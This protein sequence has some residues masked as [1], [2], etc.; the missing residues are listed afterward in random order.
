MA[1]DTNTPS[2]SLD[3][4]SSAHSDDIFA[5]N[6]QDSVFDAVQVAQAEGAAPPAPAAAATPGAPRPVEIPAGADVVRIQV[7][8]GDVLI[9]GAPFTGEAELIGR[10]GDGNLAIRVGDVTVILQGYVDANQ[11]A[12]ITVETAD[13]Q[14]ID[15]A[16]MLA[17]TDPTID[18]QTAAG[19][20]DAAAGAQGADNN[21]ALFSQFGPGGGL[22]GFRGVG[23]QDAT[24]L[25]YG[26]IDNS[27]RND[28]ADPLVTP[29]GTFGFA[30][31]PLSG[32]HSERFFRDPAQTDYLGTFAKFMEE[33]QD[34][35]ENPENPMFPGWADFQG[36]GATNGDFAEYLQQTRQTIDIDVTFTNGAGDISLDG[37]AAG[38]TSNGSP[39]HVEHADQG[40]TMF[41]RR[42]SDG[43]LV[44]VVHVETTST[45]FTIE[46]ILINRMDHPGHGTGD[47]GRDVMDIGVDFTVYDGPSPYT[48]EG[49]GNDVGSPSPSLSETATFTFEDDVPLFDNVTYDNLDGAGGDDSIT[50]SKSTGL[51]DEDWLQAGAHDTGVDGK[52]NAGDNGD[53]KGGASVHGQINITFG[54]DGPSQSDNGR[55]ETLGKHAFALDTSAYAQGQPFPYGEDGL[56]SGGQTLYVL[57]VSPN[58]LIVGIPAPEIDEIEESVAVSAVAGTP[59]FM[60]TLNQ[61]TGAFTFTLIGPLDHFSDLIFD[62]AAPAV[63]AGAENTIPL[64][65]GVTALDDDG[66]YVP[67]TIH[68]EVNDDMPVARD[69]ENTVDPGTFGPVNGNAMDNDSQG[70]DTA[71]VTGVAFEGKSGDLGTALQGEYGKLTLNADGTY[72][73]TRDPGTKGGVDD[74]FHYTLT[75]KDGD[76]SEAK[77]TIHIGDAGVTVETP[78]GRDGT[79][80]YEAGLPERNGGEPAG[81]GEI[82]DGDGTDNDDTSEATSGVVTITAKDG[83]ASLQIGSNAALTLAELNDLGSNPVSY[84]DSTGELTLTGFD[85]GTGKLSYTY[86]LLDN[87]LVDPDSRSFAIKVTDQDGSE[88]SGTLKITI[89]DDE[90]TARSDSDSVD[91]VAN[92]ATGNVITGDNTTSG[93]AG[94]DT[95]GA[96]GAEAVFLTS[97]DKAGIPDGD[98][99]NGLKVEGLYGTLEMAADGSYTYTRNSDTPLTATETF[100]YALED[101]DGDISPATLTINIDDRGVRIGDL[102]PD[103]AGGDVSVDEDDLSD[104]SDPAPKDSLTATGT[105]TISAPDGVQT[106]TIGGQPVITGGVFAATSFTTPFGNTLAVTGYNSGTGEI[107]Y[108]YKLNDNTSHASAGEDS[109]FEDFA[110]VLTD[111]DGDTAN[112]TLSAKIV[113]DVPTAKNDT[114]SLDN[115]TLTATGN[116][117]TGADTT[118]S[119]AD[120]QGADTAKVIGVS[121]TTGGNPLPDINGDTTVFGKY[122][123]LTVA[124]DGTYTYTRSDG[125]PLNDTDTF[126]YTLRDGDGDESTA[127]LT[128][129]IQD[130]DVEITNLTP[131][132]AG[133][134]VVVDEDDLPGGSDTTPESTAAAGSFNISAPDG[135]QTLTIGGEP[136]IT[137]G[138][139]TPT[140]ITTPLGNTLTVTSFVAGVISYT[141]TLNDNETHNTGGG[142]NN[143]FENLAVEL[144]DVDGD[145]KTSTLSA[146]I[147]DDIAT[148]SADT[149]AVNSGASTGDNVETNDVFGADGKSGQGVIGVATGS[150][151]TKD[152]SGNLNTDIVTSLGTLK[153]QADGTY[154]Y[155]AKPNVSGVDHFVY[156]IKDGDG[157]TSTTTL[158]ITVNQVAPKA[159]TQSVTV[160]EAALDKNL[161]SGDLAIATVTG[162]NPGLTTE[163]ATG[164]LVLGSGV[165][166]VGGNDQS[167]GTGTLHVDADGKFTYTLTSPINSGA[168]AGAN[169]VADSQVFNVTIKDADGNTSIDT[170]KISIKDDIAT[171]NAD[172]KALNSGA[173]TGDNVETN[174]VFGADGKSGQGVIGVAT[175][176]DTTKDASGNLNTDIVTSLGTLKLQADGSYT[177]TAKPNV[178][179]VDHFVYTIKDGDGDTSTTTLDITVNQVVLKTDTQS[180]T[181]DEAALDLTQDPGDLA[182]GTVTG[183]NAGSANETKTGQLVLGSGVTVVGGNDQSNATGT[184]H[185]D[186]DGKFTYTLTSPINSGA[187][188]GANTVADSQVFTVTI[189]DADGN[190]ATD[191]IKISIKDDIATANAD[192]NALNSGAT[193]TGN[194]ETNDVFGA[195]G[196]SGNG[197]VG[198][199]AGT[200]TSSPVSGGTGAVITTSLGKLTLNDNGSYTY[201]ANPNVSGVDHF[202]YTIKDG[203]G[204]LSTT[205]LDITVNQVTPKADT[206][207]VTVDEAALDLTQDP[208]D[209]AAGTVTGSNPG[210]SNETKTGQLVLGSGVTVVGGNDQSNATGTLHVDADGKFTYTLTSPINSGAAA[211]ANTVA[212]SQVF[213]VTIK[214]ADGNTATDTIKISIKD[215]IPTAD[216]DSNSVNSGATATG[217]VESDDTFGADGKSGNGVVGVAAGTDTSSPVLTGTGAM[218][219]TSLGK[220]TLNDDGSYTYVANP[221]KGGVDHF[222]YTIKDGDG[223]LST[224]TLDITVNQV[225]LKTDT[226]SATVD[227]AALDLTQDPGDLA[228]GTVTGSN[229]GSSNETKTGQLVLGSGV[230]VVGGNDQSNATG[231]LHVDADGKFTYTLTSPINSGA[232]AGANTVADAQTFNVTIQDAFGNTA[233]DTIKISIKDDIPTADPD[234]N[235]VNSGATAT[236]NVES[237]D[238]FGA[239]GKSGNGVVGVAAGN[240][241]SSPVLTGTGAVITTSLGKLTLNDDGSYTYVANPNTGGVDHFVYTI[242]DGDGDLSTTTLDI[243][244]NQVAPKADTQS[245]TVDEAA[246]DLTQ[247]P[248]DLAAGTVTGSNPGSSNETKTGQLVLGSGVTVV[249]GN[250]QSNG[251]GTLHVDADGKFTYTLTSPINSGAVAGA[252]TVADAQVFNVTIQD[253]FGNTATDTIKISITDDIPTAN[254]D[255]K[256]LNSGGSTSD[257]VEGNDGFGADGKSGGTGVVG[258]AT[259]SNTAVPVSGN[260]NTNI[261]TSLGTLKLQAD[262]SYTY[263]ANANVSG[264]DHFVYTIKDGDGDQ[265]TTTLDITVNNVTPKADTQIVTVNEAALDTILDPGDLAVSTKTGSNPSSPDETKTGQLVLGAGITATAGDYTGSFGK[266]HVNSDGSFTY[267]LTTNMNSGAVAG[268]NTVNDAEIFNIQIQDAFGN[269][270]TD[271]IKVNIVDDVPQVYDPADQSLL[272]S[273][274]GGIYTGALNTA[275]KGGADGI[276][277]VLFS[278]GTDGS[279]AMLSD[280]STPMLYQTHNILLSGFGT[281][282]LTGT[283]DINNSG[284]I[285]A[286][287]VQVFTVKLDVPNDRYEF[288]LLK[289]I[290]NGA[291]IDFTDLSN[292]KAGNGSWLGVGADA[293]DATTRDLLY[294]SK[295]GTSVNSSS[296]DVA[297]GNQWIEFGEGLRM[298]FVNGLTTGGGGADPYNFTAHY[299]VQDFQFT[300]AQIKGGASSTS[301]KVSIF[302]ATTQA[303]VAGTTATDFGLETAVALS[304]GE[305]SVLRGGV[306]ASG[307]TITFSSGVATIAGIQ[308]GDVIQI[309]EATGFDR[310]LVESGDNK[311]ADFAISSSKVLNTST[312]VDLDTRFETTL[313]DG[314]GDTSKGQYIGINLQTDDGQAHTFTGGS[315]NDTMHGGI[316]NDTLTGGSGNDL[317]FG[318]AGNDTMLYDSADKYDGGAGFDRVKVDGAGGTNLS[319]TSANFISIEMID[320]GDSSDRNGAGQNTLSLNATDLIAAN[321]GASTAIPGHNIN[322]FVIG[323]T[324]GA[325]TTEHDNVVLTGFGGKLATGVAFVDPNTGIS[326]NYDVYATTANP[327]VK[328]A[329]ETNLDVT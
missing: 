245:V 243:T 124:A 220:L 226:Q 309:D 123:V 274:L 158:D 255:T 113:D 185:V 189:Q 178:Q 143:L 3:R 203:D 300:L 73:Y 103:T 112:S 266:L 45:G 228:A 275:G 34:A 28:F 238:T 38:L 60:L 22:G 295:T 261:V 322:L 77:L 82:A 142:E 54:A 294:T 164:Q 311:S 88:G 107:T 170:I 69:D 254:A 105:F 171:A 43:A 315:G 237:D 23:A 167:N 155:T 52:S 159:D 104:G 208:G 76:T 329:I 132:T 283:A 232:V 97:I 41:V 20:G 304:A 102:N 181:V 129:N 257:N 219:T 328:V 81:S 325:G 299:Q 165:T 10:I 218:I 223:D 108:T 134:D 115:V 175:G 27:I 249:G 174:D 146:K 98:N 37:V 128:I 270:A 293:G 235:A 118:S 154:T 36:T 179:G 13:G 172:T 126:T 260:L 65:F 224:T 90:P 212:D 95:T 183:S 55:Y 49:E 137:G 268:A 72:A 4:D 7:Q 161:D 285:D 324:A 67:A 323:D 326:H 93:A 277:S 242:K 86:T 160:D 188:A 156:T 14:P 131:D 321:G 152:A 120:T 298:D 136:V 94:A 307:I 19:P 25:N 29:L 198:V 252:N 184:L 148:A 292:A 267:T 195:D 84:K 196:K 33:Y 186:A 222:V 141:Y 42:D 291:K 214:D 244:V 99:S 1:T 85:E 271:Q 53:T 78:S 68:I 48:Q 109:K 74:I 79:I 147:V 190:T 227:E 302:D 209:L 316:G 217:N 122:G 71:V 269:K 40:H 259:G 239:D 192:T 162:S 64:D 273:A 213:N 204:D 282:T 319:F 194:V 278:G 206:Q 284:K 70:A 2:G 110:V 47:A 12:P 276:A 233:T 225:V 215:D 111:V 135:I 39:L 247:D 231:T 89:V 145:T 256:A 272:N 210:S 32:G 200:D 262:G 280:G 116:V 18:I 6:E 130:Q 201:V 258:V 121:S 66:D 187:V 197:V 230:T 264:V 296:N 312:G 92:T 61:D 240:D 150:D 83:V 149:K 205:T 157:D 133:G 310:L 234:T 313:T 290:D 327:A 153:L 139:F 287:D 281:T 253:A 26:L 63:V 286:G 193:A 119:G 50:K 58:Q 151:T 127:T 57:L 199:V 30:I 301:I 177:Y 265:S 246:L 303:N 168:V 221:N 75:D 59:I 163:T 288:N 248:G 51:I 173:S 229:S 138:V 17:S 46:T 317:I 5:A 91:N 297:T 191:T 250:D 125:T 100:G 101:G 117:I 44:A 314:D 263:T 21:G 16:V 114:D 24:E 180:V 106:L 176:S 251:T 182:A 211:G 96:D 320:L 308:Q 80:V 9:L 8:P 207:S 56:T 144:T 166:V 62:D 169:T 35:V 15:V 140:I 216:P 318:D 306:A 241:T 305:V 31:G 87:T 202:V 289:P 279:K 11:Q 236:G